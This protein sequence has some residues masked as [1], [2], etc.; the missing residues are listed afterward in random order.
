MFRANHIAGLF[1]IKEEEEEEKAMINGKSSANH[2]KTR[3]H[4][5]I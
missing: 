1:D 3:G 2:P 5:Q 4:F